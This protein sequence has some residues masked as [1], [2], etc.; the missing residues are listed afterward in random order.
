[1]LAPDPTDPRTAVAV[2]LLGLVLIVA[3]NVAATQ[4]GRRR[5]RAAQVILGRFVDRL[6][7]AITYHLPSRQRYRADEIT[8]YFWINGL[9]P[10]GRDYRALV[11]EGFRTWRLEVS[12]LVAAPFELSLDGLRRLPRQTQ[13]TKH[14]CIQGWSGV[15]QWSGVPLQA[16][17]DRC[18][19]LPEARH[20]VVWAFDDK[21]LTQPGTEGFYYE[22]VDIALARRPQA[23]LAYEFNGRPLPVEHGAPLRLRLEEQL[24]F[25]MV[26]WIR[27]ITFERDFRHLGLGYGGWREDHAYYSRVV[28][29]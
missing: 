6:Q 13:I 7:A 25:K 26:K 22:S 19:V 5:P 29:F 2:A 8:P 12:G 23:L 20:M 16:F 10:H 1:V 14:N 28:G 11:E 15:A 27:A 18:R 9:P 4:L 3:V 17:I 24:G 21:R